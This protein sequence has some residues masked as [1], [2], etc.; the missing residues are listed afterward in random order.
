MASGNL[1]W[2]NFMTIVLAIPMLD[3]R[4]FRFIAALKPAALAEPH[5]VH[6]GAILAITAVVVY[7]SINPVR[8]MLSPRQVMNT[9]YNP[10]HL[11]GT[12]GAFG[13]ITRTRYEVVVEGTDDPAPSDSTKWREYEF[14][15][16]PG[17]PARLPPQI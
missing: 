15:G 13:G 1:S 6:K 7:L 5:L 14:K 10:Y 12:Y 16:K 3:D 9:E 4:L 8:N 2:L 17:D 11:V